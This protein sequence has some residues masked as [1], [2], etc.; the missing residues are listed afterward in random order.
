MTTD[1]VAVL[2]TGVDSFLPYVQESGELHDPVFD[3][4]TQYGTAYHAYC[5]AVLAETGPAAHRA[6]RLA[7]AGRGLDAAL[8]HTENPDLPPTGASFSRADGSVRRSNHRDFTWPPI[9]KT[10]RVLRDAGDGRTAEFAGRIAAVDLMRSFRSRP[11]SNWASVWLSGEWI[12]IREGLSPYSVADVDE[13][14]A[15][16]LADLLRPETGFYFEPGKPNSY[17]LFTRLHVADLLV[18]G[19]DGRHRPALERLMATGLERSLAVQLSDGSLAS[20]HRSAGQTWTL[21]AQ[22][23]YFT[24]ARAYF[25]ERQDTERADRAAEAATRAFVSMRRWQRP[26]ATFSPVENVLPEGWRVG[27]EAY[28]A[29]GHYANLALAFLA[30]AVRAGFTGTAPLPAERTP[31]TR[32]EHDPTFR[33]VASAGRYSVAVNADPAPAYDGFGITDLTV[34]PDR[35]L[36][37]ASSVRHLESGRF[38]N[39]GT[40][41]R[42][43][44]VRG[45]LDVLAQRTFALDAPIEAI[46]AADAFDAVHLDGAESRAGALAGLRVRGRSDADGGADA[47]PYRLEVTVH[48]DGVH[49]DEAT[50][51]VAGERTLLVPYLR[52]PGT[53]VHTQVERTPHGVRLVHGEEVLDVNVE[54]P[55]EAMV[56]LPYGF[57]NRRGLCGLVRL[58]LTGVHD[59]VRFTVTV[60]R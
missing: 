10:F 24:H 13:W 50:P 32:V 12:R 7:R 41:L 43:G 9:L 60:E 40:A 26:G 46:Q 34:G 38:L 44:G 56:H 29:D 15:V 17:D 16:F 20:A 39:L 30:T 59:T 28:T 48:D 45:D 37:F 47:M 8:A 27:Y 5:Q 36:Q 6:D 35:H 53:G 11:P 22:V 33:G 19:Y 1:S 31:A 2:T 23:A 55:V 49:V 18:E 57:E 14:L 51:G 3:E 42:S 4:P 21:G 52:D 54:V 25:T 58:D